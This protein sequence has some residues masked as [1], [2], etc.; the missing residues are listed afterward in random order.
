MSSRQGPIILE[1][2]GCSVDKGIPRRCYLHD[3]RLRYDQNE[4]AK[5]DPDEMLW[6]PREN[7]TE[8]LDRQIVAVKA[9]HDGTKSAQRKRRHW[10]AFLLL[11]GIKSEYERRRLL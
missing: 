8:W 3:V 7:F 5:T 6:P 1:K 10:D 4:V 2:C 9:M 11:Q